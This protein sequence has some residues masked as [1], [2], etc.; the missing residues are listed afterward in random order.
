MEGQGTLQTSKASDWTQNTRLEGGR[1]DHT[2]LIFLKR[3][4]ADNKELKVN[5]L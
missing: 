1:R 5:Y 3:G 2:N 4:N